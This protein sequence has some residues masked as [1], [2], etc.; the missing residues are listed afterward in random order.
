M[1]CVVSLSFE[2]YTSN[3]YVR[4]TLAG[5]FV[6]VSRHLLQDLIELG[7]WSPELKNKMI[8]NNGSVQSIEEIPDHIK[9]LYKTVWEVR[10]Q[11]KQKSNTTLII[12][13]SI[14]VH[15]LC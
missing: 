13:S 6:C 15:L 10:Q 8:A 11:N 14:H 1:C 3:I 2:P 4:R 5:E 9:A 7:I 12:A